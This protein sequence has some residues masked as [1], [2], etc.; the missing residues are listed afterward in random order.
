MTSPLRIPE[1]LNR[2]RWELMAPRWTSWALWVRTAIRWA[3]RA[4]GAARDRPRRPLEAL[5]RIAEAMLMENVLVCLRR[6][7]CWSRVAEGKG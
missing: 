6:M 5:K 7:R 1:Q 2:R 4:R 3:G